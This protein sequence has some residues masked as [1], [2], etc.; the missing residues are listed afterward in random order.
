M[1]ERHTAIPPLGAVR[2][3]MYY[4]PEAGRLLR[5][6]TGE[7]VPFTYPGGTP[8][9]HVRVAQR[10]VPA[11]HIAWALYTGEWS[12]DIFL[13]YATNRVEDLRP[14]NMRQF[15]ANPRHNLAVH[16]IGRQLP[17]G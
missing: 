1:I 14:G 4:D 6:V 9:P 16:G 8:W 12:L 3:A 11:I 13:G 7:P 10:A 5:H 17:P 15:H 2:Q